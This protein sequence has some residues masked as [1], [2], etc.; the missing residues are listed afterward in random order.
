[1]FRFSNVTLQVIFHTVQ[2]VELNTAP[3]NLTSSHVLFCS[4]FSIN[5]NLKNL[6]AANTQT[7]VGGAGT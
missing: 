2:H 5:K 1:M 4:S 3:L 7:Q 6:K